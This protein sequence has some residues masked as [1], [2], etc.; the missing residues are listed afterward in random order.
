MS[1]AITA[2]AIDRAAFTA[3]LT[4]PACGACVIFDGW[5]RNHNDGR[6]VERLE[7][8]V[9]RPLALTE[10]EKILA[11]AREKFAV[12]RVACVHREGLLQLGEP[13]VLVGASAPHREAAF[14]AARYVIDE[15]KRRLP[16]WK[17]EH[18][19]DGE[20]R[21]VNCR[22]C[23]AAHGTEGHGAEAHGD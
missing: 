3:V 15:A 7:Y 16:I 23:G 8:E 18:Y 21:W 22:H 5:I 12:R 13:A 17:K 20:A 9:Y 10:G 1:F 14:L 19:V 2:K 11:E 6:A 4:D